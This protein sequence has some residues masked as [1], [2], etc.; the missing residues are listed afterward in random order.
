MNVQQAAKAHEKLRNR[1]YKIQHEIQNAVYELEQEFDD[2]RD[3]ATAD[4]RAKLQAEKGLAEALQMEEEALK[5]LNAARLAQEP[6]I[7]PG[8][9]YVMWKRNRFDRS[10]YK[11]MDG[12]IEIW[13]AKSVRPQNLPS[14]RKPAVGDLVIRH[15]NKAGQPG[16]KFTPVGKGYGQTKIDLN[17]PSWNWYAEGVMPK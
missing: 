4:L 17:N 7:K 14:Y 2:R 8:T 12:V 5:V 3:K 9:K 16:K 10:Y 13:T 1:V 15:L 6:A 11:E